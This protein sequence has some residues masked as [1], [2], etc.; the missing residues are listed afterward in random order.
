MSGNIL[1]GKGILR[2]VYGNEEGKGMLRASYGSLIKNFFLIPPHPLTNFE[3][4]KYRQNETRFNGVYS[5][6]NL[7]KK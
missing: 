5:G 3:I 6:D 4:Q 7:P 1:T 2:A